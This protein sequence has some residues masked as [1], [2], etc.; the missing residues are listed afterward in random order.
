MA[1]LH[2]G[3]LDITNSAQSLTDLL[4]LSDKRYF[5]SCIVRA[6]VSN[7][8]KL[9]FGPASV[10]SSTNRRGFIEAGEWFEIEIAQ[11]W[12]HTSGIYF[13]STVASGDKLFCT[14]V[15]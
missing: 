1:E 15:Y 3:E 5:Q 8:G 10:T 2:G 9:W 7:A 13:I 12:T 11:G 4:G 14:M 6:D